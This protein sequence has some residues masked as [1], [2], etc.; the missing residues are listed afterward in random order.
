M[1]LAQVALKLQTARSRLTPRT[2]AILLATLLTIGVVAVLKNQ[3]KPVEQRPAV[4]L[5]KIDYAKLAKKKVEDA[6]QQDELALK[7]FEASLRNALGTYGIK[8]AEAAEAI[9]AQ[10]SQPDAMA[11]I[12]FYLAKDQITSGHQTDDYLNN[13]IQPIFVPIVDEFGNA[14]SFATAT[15]E[16]DLR[17]T[18]VQLAIDLASI[19][20]GASENN[21]RTV[22]DADIRR[23]FDSAVRNLGINV[24]VTVVLVPLDVASLIGSKGGPGIL[25]GIRALASRMFAKQVVK[26]AATPALASIPSPL[27]IPQLIAV[28]SL[29]WT[30]YGIYQMQNEFHDEVST[31]ITDKLGEIS[32][33]MKIRANDFA[34]GKLNEHRSVQTAMADNT[35]KAF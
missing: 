19:G 22:P 12:V 24:A 29:A 32:K 5:P 18:S 16:N 8:S 30:A 21:R 1:G 14:V 9:S 31:S 13:L 3:K 17:R 33:A 2:L 23:E 27:P 25:K 10:A 28:A 4:T 15:F 7:R 6:I 26:L 11:A 20:P 34:L 35:I